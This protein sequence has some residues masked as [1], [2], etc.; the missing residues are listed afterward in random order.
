MTARQERIEALRAKIIR[1][2]IDAA[3]NMRSP[4][5]DWQAI[6]AHNA[7]NHRTVLNRYPEIAAYWAAKRK[8]G[9]HA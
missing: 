9:A 7:I 4:D 8:E 3:N 5:C 2:G 1:R 6:R